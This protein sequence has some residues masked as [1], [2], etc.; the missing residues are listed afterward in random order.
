MV[1]G[2]PAKGGDSHVAEY[3]LSEGK[4]PAPSFNGEDDVVT[5]DTQLWK[6]LN[7]PKM[8]RW[9]SMLLHS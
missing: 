5:D 9:V 4:L 1:E 3:L 7:V 6:H 2:S 8:I